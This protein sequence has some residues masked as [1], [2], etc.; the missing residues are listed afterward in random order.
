LIAS[1]RAEEAENNPVLRA[2]FERLH[3]L[4]G[5]VEVRHVE[6]GALDPTEAETLS[7]ALLEADHRSGEI[8]A[9]AMVRA[10]VGEARGNPFLAGH[11]PA[12]AVET[13]DAAGAPGPRPGGD[14]GAFRAGGMGG[15]PEPARRLLEVVAVAGQPIARAVAARAAYGD[16]PE[17]QELAALSLLRA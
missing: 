14:P 3:G 12:R 10:I 17:S 1:Y 13:P 8:L 11:H 6:V 5:Q 9:E 15:L 16:E 2:F 7:R 4:G